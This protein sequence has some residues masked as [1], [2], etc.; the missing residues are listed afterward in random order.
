LTDLHADRLADQLTAVRRAQVPARAFVL[1]TLQ[2]L[3]LA[4]TGIV[5]WLGG[6]E[7][8]SLLPLL[9]WKRAI[10]LKFGIVFVF[11]ALATLAPSYLARRGL[12]A[13]CAFYF[14]VVTWNVLVMCAL[15]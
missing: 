6:D 15:S 7:R 2:I 14:A 10:V 5:L 1:L 8:N 13:V 12:W 9:G 3:D 11:A 4:S